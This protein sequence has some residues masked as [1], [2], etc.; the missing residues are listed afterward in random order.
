[1]RVGVRVR[2]IAEFLCKPYRG[3]RVGLRMTVGGRKKKKSLVII[4]D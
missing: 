1:M 3:G 2:T 4:A